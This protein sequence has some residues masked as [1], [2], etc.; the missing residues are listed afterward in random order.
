MMSST[1]TE[2]QHRAWRK[3]E[4]RYK[5]TMTTVAIGS[6]S[7]LPSLLGALLRQ[8]MYFPYKFPHRLFSLQLCEK[9]RDTRAGHL[10]L[11]VAGH[12]RWLVVGCHLCA[13]PWSVSWALGCFILWFLCLCLSK[14]YV[15]ML[16][17]KPKSMKWCSY[18]KLIQINEEFLLSLCFFFFLFSLLILMGFHL[19][20]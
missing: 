8:D 20:P 1:V 10:L 6:A 16:Q 2:L 11:P 18:S 7:K 12:C 19:R 3:V 9:S 4:F 15:Q 14:M 17:T 5:R 13:Q